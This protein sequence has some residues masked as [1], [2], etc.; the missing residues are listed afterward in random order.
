MRTCDGSVVVY[1]QMRRRAGLWAIAA[2]VVVVVVAVVGV[3]VVAMGSCSEFE[4]VLRNVVAPLVTVRLN[5]EM[6]AAAR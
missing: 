5:G 1:L 6:F 3:G 2:V 4:R